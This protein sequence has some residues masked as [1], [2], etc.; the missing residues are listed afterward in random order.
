ML[1]LLAFLVAA[2]ASPPGAGIPT[3]PKPA[4]QPAV[5]AR[6]AQHYSLA[7]AARAAVLRGDVDTAQAQGRALGALGSDG[8]PASWKPFL[9][10]LSQSG[11]ELANAPDIAQAAAAVGRIATACSDCHAQ[12]DGGPVVATPSAEPP[13]W[14][15]ETHMTRH[16]WASDWIWMGVLANDDALLKRGATLLAKD[17]AVSPSGTPEPWVLE[18][19]TQTHRIAKEMLDAPDLASRRALYGPLL[20]QCGTCHERLETE[21]STPDGDAP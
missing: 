8:L 7:A 13:A 18:L 19:E 3:E 21:G 4:E 10:E 2:H 15:A 1:P 6:M 5:H 16:L 11:R 12:L 20:A 14:S 9:S 17:P